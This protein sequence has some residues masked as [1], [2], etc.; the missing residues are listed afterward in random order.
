MNPNFDNVDPIYSRKNIYQIF[1]ISVEFLIKSVV[2]MCSMSSGLVDS[3]SLVVSLLA[4]FMLP[5]LS[6][7]W[8]R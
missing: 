6:S 8:L 5:K 4:V 3:F 7:P 2:V 1:H